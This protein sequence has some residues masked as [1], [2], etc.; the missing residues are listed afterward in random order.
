MG[1]DK[2]KYKIIGSSIIAAFASS[3]CCIAPLIAILAGLGG[4]ASAVSWLDPFRPY[5]F[6]F[7]ML[8][9]GYAFYEAYKP[10]KEIDCNC[11]A[12]EKR[13]FIR[14]KAFLWVI[15]ILNI[16]LFTFPYYAE[17]L[18]PNTNIVH[19]VDNTKYN[20]AVLEI[21]GMTCTGCENTVNYAL[22]SQNGVLSAS[23][24]YK[25]GIAKVKYDKSKISPEKL[26]EAIEK[27]GTYKVKM[28]K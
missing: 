19:T 3:L 26:T 23:S 9:L 22:K 14:S 13:S 5:L 18:F 28:I 25:T 21:E 27:T 6:G 17:A 11:E 12:N 15:A 24:S 1:N 16:T 20:E 7:S 2:N 8:A 10:K 4:I